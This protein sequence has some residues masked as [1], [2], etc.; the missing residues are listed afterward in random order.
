MIEEFSEL[1][2]Q[3]H[4]CKG[5]LIKLPNRNLSTPKKATYKLNIDLTNKD[6]VFDHAKRRRESNI[7]RWGKS[8]NVKNKQADEYGVLGERGFQDL[9]GMPMD[10]R[11]GPRSPYDFKAKDLE[12]DIKCTTGHWLSVKRGRLLGHEHKDYWYVLCVG[13]LETFDVEFV[14]CISG[15]M[16]RNKGRHFEEDDGFGVHED[17]LDPIDKMYNMLKERGCLNSCGEWK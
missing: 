6:F 14:G 1:E 2:G 17:N 10:T 15:D 4:K 3:S 12:I 11:I 7:E 9:T 8:L 5:Q 16:V 13:N